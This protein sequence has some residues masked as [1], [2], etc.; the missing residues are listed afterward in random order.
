VSVLAL[1]PARGGSKGIPRKNLVPVNGKPLI[2]HTI[3]LAKRC[4]TIDRVIVSTEDA[5]IAAVA[6]KFGAEVPFT[7]PMELAG[8]F[9]TDLEVFHHAL[10]WLKKNEAYEPELVVQLR[11]TGPVRRAE[12]ID[13]AV[14]MMKKDPS[15]DSLRAVSPALQT[16]YKMWR[17]DGPA[18]SPLLTLEGEAEPYNLPRQKLPQVYW[19]N[20]YVDILRPRVVLEKNQMNGAKIL[21]LVVDEPILEIDYPDMLPKVEE[22][23]RLLEKGQWPPKKEAARH[24][25]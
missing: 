20:G 2:A 18:L 7:R 12:L 14:A 17:L 6:K 11:A 5:E 24:A 21:G 8:D 4:K 19:Q 22:A 15:A 3:E 1:I 23:L 25:V 13:Q 16:P 9:S 10:T